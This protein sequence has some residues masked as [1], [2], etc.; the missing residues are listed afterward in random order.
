M[1]S[2]VLSLHSRMAVNLIC[3]APTWVS[4][5]MAAC[6]YA[7]IINLEMSSCSSVSVKCDCW[8]SWN[9][10]VR[11]K[12]VFGFVFGTLTTGIKTWILAVCS[13]HS[14]VQNPVPLA[15]WH[16]ELLRLYRCEGVWAV[17]LFHRRWPTICPDSKC[18]PKPGQ[19]LTPRHL[20]WN[21]GALSRALKRGQGFRF[22]PHLLC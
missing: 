3:P 11:R 21:S 22:V 10:E 18:S 9:V 13:P 19:Q 12:V 5:L 6:V 20:C 16:I 7:Q 14:S 17:K 2:P 8:P 4:I 1:P 15:G